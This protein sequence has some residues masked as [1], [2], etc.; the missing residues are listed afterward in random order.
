MAK[1]DYMT[2]R[3]TDID[4]RSLSHEEIDT[5]LAS[6]IE[7]YEAAIARRG[8]RR[9]KREGHIVERVAGIRN[10]READMIAQKGKLMRT[11]YAGGKMTRVADRHIRRHNAR[12]EE[13]L[14]KLQMMILTG[15]FPPCRYTME[16]VVTHNG[17]KREIIKFAFF[18]WRVFHHALLRPIEQRVN[19]SMI[20]ETFAC[21]KGRGLHFGVRLLK[22]ALRRHPELKWFWKTD[23]KKFYQSIPHRLIEEEFRALYKDEAF[24]SLI[25]MTLEAYI[26]GEEI[27][28]IMEDER[29]RRERNTHWSSNKP[30]V[31]EPCRKKNRPRSSGKLKGADVSKVLRRCSRTCREQGSGEKNATEILPARRKERTV[32]Q[33]EHHHLAY[34]EGSRQ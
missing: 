2:A 16:N 3:I 25:R 23:F 13:D 7:R 24:V 21:I 10:L 19:A 4:W 34:R 26:S 33:V 31:R 1:T 9:P 11:V 20:P 29:T 27:T 32:H 18:P 5:I 15:E 14:R 6:R 30:D 28:R 8:G 17:K 12:A 22:K